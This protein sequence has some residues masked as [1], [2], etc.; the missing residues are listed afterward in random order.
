MS[1]GNVPIERG[2]TNAHCSLVSA[3]PKKYELSKPHKK[4]ANTSAG[5]LFSSSGL[6]WAMN[7]PPFSR[8]TAKP[9]IS[10]PSKPSSAVFQQPVMIVGV[11]WLCS[12]IH[13]R[14]V[15]TRVCCLC[16]TATFYKKEHEPNEQETERMK[17]RK[18]NELC[19]MKCRTHPDWRYATNL[20]ASNPQGYDVRCVNSLVV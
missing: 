15:G 20:G 8:L 1:D 7:V 5:F 14:A 18:R 6:F 3:L 2:D 19:L 16:F 12:S 11:N 13:H 17:S 9:A 10:H 4:K